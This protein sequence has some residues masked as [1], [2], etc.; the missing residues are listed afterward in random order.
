M[1]RSLS[2]EWVTPIDLMQNFSFFEV[3]EG[4]SSKVISSLKGQ[5]Q[6]GRRISVELAGQGGSN[7]GGGGGQFNRRGTSGGGYGNRDRGGKR[8]F[9][10][11]AS[12]DGGKKEQ[13]KGGRK[14]KY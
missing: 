3:P 1:Y 12:S 11:R 5:E 10:S 4:D 2:L 13:R 14:P 8:D 9:G 7:G 6:N